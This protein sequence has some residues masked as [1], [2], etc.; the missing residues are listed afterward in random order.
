MN[1]S[2]LEWVSIPFG[3]FPVKSFC[4]CAFGDR[5]RPLQPGSTRNPPKCQIFPLA[6]LTWAQT[7]R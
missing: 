3:N 4:F 7:G 2:R 6:P 1:A 5:P